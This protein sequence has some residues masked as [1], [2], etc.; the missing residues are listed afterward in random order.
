MLKL[1]IEKIISY[2]KEM[3]IVDTGNGQLGVYVIVE[4][5]DN[6][7]VDNEVIESKFQ[8]VV[9]KDN[10]YLGRN[11]IIYFTDM[12][13]GEEKIFDAIEYSIAKM[14]EAIEKAQLLAN[15]TIELK[16]LFEDENIPIEQLRQVAIS[17]KGNNLTHI[18]ETSP[19]ETNKTDIPSIETDTNVERRFRCPE[20]SN[21]DNADTIIEDNMT[22]NDITDEPQIDETSPTETN[23]FS[24]VTTVFKKARKK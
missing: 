13:V 21:E 18:D 19:T 10:E 7:V 3:N 24:A 9:K 23:K 20:S 14:K 11:R 1:R 12:G 8:V 2:F 6:W 22:N 4:Y 16:R 5:P 17:I 15:K